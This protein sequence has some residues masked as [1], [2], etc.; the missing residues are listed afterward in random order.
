VV[1]FSRTQAIVT[2]GLLPPD[3]RTTYGF[4]WTPAQQRRF[5][6][7]LAFLRGVRRRTPS[8]IAQWRIAR[9]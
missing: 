6:R 2:I 8:R 7:T 4:E 9:P 1:P 3:V 5:D